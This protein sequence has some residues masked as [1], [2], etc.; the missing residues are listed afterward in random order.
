MNDFIS[1]IGSGRQ[2]LE[3]LDYFN[4]KR[5]IAKEYHRSL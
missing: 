4:N 5:R 3:V 2:G 1:A